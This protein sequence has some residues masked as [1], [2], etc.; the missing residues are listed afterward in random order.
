MIYN[1]IQTPESGRYS[2][3]TGN[4]KKI[5]YVGRLVEVKGVRVLVYALKNLLEDGEEAELDIL[6]DGVQKEEFIQLAN[7]LG[8]GNSVHFR[9]KILENRD[10]L[11]RLIYLCILRYGRKLLEFLL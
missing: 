4:L 7:Q 6:G 9:G 10:T 11:M 3:N 2:L 8:I 5:L 1:G